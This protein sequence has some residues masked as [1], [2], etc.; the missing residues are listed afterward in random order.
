MTSIAEFDNVTKI[1]DNIVVGV[2]EISLEIHEGITGFLGPNG[3]GK[4][5]SLKLL[6]GELRPTMGTVRVLDQ[7]P[8]NNPSL[9]R[10]IAY[11][12]EVNSQFDFLSPHQLLTHLARLWGKPKEQARK[13]ADDSLARMGLGEFKD[14]RLTALS[15]RMKQ[16]T[17]IAAA[18]MF[19]RSFV[20][21]D[22]PLSG[23]DPFGRNLVITL[24]KEMADDGTS[25][26][27]S[28]HILFEV[29]KITDDLILVYNGQV[30]ATGKTKAIR[31][32]LSDF[33][34]TFEIETRDPSALSSAL[35]SKPGLVSAV[36]IKGLG[37]I[38][39]GR[40]TTVLH[41]TTT[42]PREMQAEVMK[43]SSEG[44]TV[45]QLKNIEED[46]QTETIFQY[47]IQ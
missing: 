1:Y 33:P 6:A 18:L 10:Q 3:A 7:N 15:K 19:P 23:L 26:L 16:R 45:Y 30:V 5:T 35:L 32:Q 11:I 28:S 14:R 20:M 17:K 36:E 42:N 47:L 21:A 22:E 4:S 24:L 37:T 38:N 13:I 25:V 27:V 41:I 40:K 34:Y 2:S 43:L 9:Q 29:E 8:W 12:S 44:L 31:E 39:N 46:V